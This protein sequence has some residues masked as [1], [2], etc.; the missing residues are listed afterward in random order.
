MR[1]G[2]FVMDESPD[3]HQAQEGNEDMTL[4]D[5]E[6]EIQQKGSFKTLQ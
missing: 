4:A 1:S 5:I 3:H 2:M 6:G